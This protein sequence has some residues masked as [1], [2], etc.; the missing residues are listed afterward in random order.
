MLSNMVIFTF[1]MANLAVFNVCATE[2]INHFFQRPAILKKL[3][4]T[5]ITGQILKRYSQKLKL[6]RDINILYVFSASC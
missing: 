4:F 1:Y 3:F 5:V 2:T 6:R